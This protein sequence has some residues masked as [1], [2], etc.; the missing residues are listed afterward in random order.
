MN[1]ISHR[2]AIMT[3]SPLA[4]SS[5]NIGRETKCPIMTRTL[6][7]MLPTD[8][9]V[10]EMM[11][12]CKRGQSAR[13]TAHI[14]FRGCGKLMLRIMELKKMSYPGNEYTQGERGG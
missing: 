9:E 1:G 3:D 11:V 13:I 10:V 12:L 5:I 6:L 14:V 2:H 4:I 8:S 7:M